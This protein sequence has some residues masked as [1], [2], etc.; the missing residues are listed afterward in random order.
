M[1]NVEGVPTQSIRSD[2]ASRPRA[3]LSVA[4]SQADPALQQFIQGSCCR[5]ALDL[6][7]AHLPAE[8][9]VDGLL[10]VAATIMAKETTCLLVL[11][12]RRLILVAPAPQAVSWPLTTI[13]K[14]QFVPNSATHVHAGGAEFMLGADAK[15]TAGG[16]R[17]EGLVK[18]AVA[19]AVLSSA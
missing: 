8:E 4:I 11:T 7:H 16:K 10:P 3:D 18:F 12:E 5:R 1:T 15:T 6:L 19:R 2:A 17:F 9:R 13:T 14:F